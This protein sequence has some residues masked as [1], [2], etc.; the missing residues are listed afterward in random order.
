MLNQCHMVYSYIKLYYHQVTCGSVSER[1]CRDL[2]GS[3]FD[4]EF[5]WDFSSSNSLFPN[6]ACVWWDFRWLEILDS[7]YRPVDFP[8]RRCCLMPYC[9]RKHRP[10]CCY[11]KKLLYI[12]LDYIHVSCYK[13][14]ISKG[15]LKQLAMS[16]CSNTDYVTKIIML[17]YPIRRFHE[18]YMSISYCPLDVLA[19]AAPEFLS[20]F[21]SLFCWDSSISPSVAACLALTGSSSVLPCPF[22]VATQK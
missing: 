12:W 19:K 11:V 13:N 6:I 20:C 17:N 7:L 3:A 4:L 15:V 22:V 16:G 5:A 21:A 14:E 10:L 18:I 9:L 1:R 2:L 8:F